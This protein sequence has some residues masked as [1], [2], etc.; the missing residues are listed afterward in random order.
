VL[1]PAFQILYNYCEPTAVE[2]YTC[3]FC[4]HELW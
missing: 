2:K 1:H 3:N 4:P